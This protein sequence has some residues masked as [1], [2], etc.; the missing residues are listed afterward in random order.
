VLLTIN[1]HEHLSAAGLDKDTIKHSLPMQYVLL[2][3]GVLLEQSG[4]GR[5]HA[6]CP[7]H[8]DDNPSFDIYRVDGEGFD[9]VGCWSCR[10]PW[11][12]DVIDFIQ[13]WKSCDF[14][15]ALR[16]AN[17]IHREYK[18]DGEWKAIEVSDTTRVKVDPE[19]LLDAVTMSRELI[20]T[21]KTAVSEFLIEKAQKDVGFVGMDQDW[22]IDEFKL[23]AL[24]EQTIIIPHFNPEGALTAYKH[25][26]AYRPPFTAP[27]A[28]LTE[29]YGSWRMKGHGRVIVCEGESDTWVTAWTFREDS[30]DVVGLPSGASANVKDEWKRLLQD[31]QV[32][33]LF[34]GDPAGRTAAKR[35]YQ[36]LTGTAAHVWVASVDDDADA[37]STANLKQV[38]E[39]ALAIP[40]D[41]GGF[42]VDV[43]RY[44]RPTR[45]AQIALSNF[46]FMPSRLLEHHHGDGFAYEGR[47]MPDNTQC[48]LTVDDLRNKKALSSW[49]SRFNLQWFGSDTESQKLAHWLRQQA[50]FLSRGTMTD[51]AGWQPDTGSFVFPKPGDSRASLTIPARPHW[52]YVPGVNNTQLHERINLIQGDFSTTGFEAMLHLHDP[53]VVHP[54]VAWIAA[55]P[56]RSM[57]KQFPILNV[58]GGAGWGKT[59][60]IYTIMRVF[61][62]GGEASLTGT[63]KFS[64]ESL[65]QSTN[66]SP[67]WIDE[68][69]KGAREDTKL[70][71]EQMLRDAWDAK[72]TLR[73][74]MNQNNLMQLTERK[75][76]APVIVTGEEAFQETSHLERSAVISIPKDGKNTRAKAVVEATDMSGFGYTYLAWLAET[77][78]SRRDD[79]PMPVQPPESDRPAWVKAIL[80]WG[81]ELLAMFSEEV[82]HYDIG[83]IDL[84]FIDHSIE[85]A[86]ESS[87]ILEA[88]AWAVDRPTVGDKLPTVWFEGD[89]VL[90]RVTD[91]TELVQKSGSFYLPAK[92]L[93]LHHGLPENHP[94]EKVK[95]D[96]LG[97]YK[98][99]LRLRGARASIEKRMEAS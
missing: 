52:S 86:R 36:A 98:R 74:G 48:T 60:L 11:H 49:S 66:A 83:P 72:S 88:V 47:L 87:P 97:P 85:E 16:I 22:L 31:K 29:L 41:P 5:L 92:W 42:D 7:F 1:W 55:A 76:I 17:D 54:I 51:V 25:R 3:A 82:M 24:D 9:R 10:V 44:V 96:T 64:V 33:I 2:K 14:K 15:E 35:W 84:S 39:R 59:T 23:G 99:A 90:I 37:S 46:V 80:T 34:D 70:A 89:D 53:G 94:M 38:V 95:Y 4:D 19:V 73:G 13:T 75:T 93:R 12:A 28:S 18:A 8:P 81:W 67:V 21:S 30:V 50:P 27:G 69:R 91:F 62:W 78:R 32:T 71:F 79:L 56:F 77:Y 65:M 58:T 40:Q 68:Y 45:D 6:L 63:T 26:T 20:K 61:G 57:V 43:H